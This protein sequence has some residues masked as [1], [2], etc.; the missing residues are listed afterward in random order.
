MRVP[1]FLVL[2]FSLY[3]SSVQPLT[4]ETRYLVGGPL[5][6]VEVPKFPTQHG[7]PDGHPGAT[8]QTEGE[9]Q[10]TTE[11]L[12][13]E[14]QLYPGSVEH[15]RAYMFKYMPIRS[16][17]DVQSQLKNW[18]APNIPGAQ[19]QHSEQYA[20]S[21]F[22]VPRHSAVR[23]TGLKLKPE[24]VIR[25]KVGTPEFELDLGEL[26]IG[27]Y[28]IRVI[29]A[30]APEQVKD[31]RL[32]AFLR[33]SVNDGLLGETSNYRL[34]IGY[35]EEFY[36]V[37]EFYFYAPAKRPYQSRLALDSGSQVDLLVHNVSLDDV[38]AG[39]ENRVLKKRTTIRS[40]VPDAAAKLEARRK[41]GH[42]IREPLSN[43]DRLTRDARIWNAF[44]P[45]NAQ[46][47]SRMGTGYGTVA[48]VVSGT[49]KMNAKE[50]E[51]EYGQWA[52]VSGNKK[53]D[54]FPANAILE[55]C[56]LFNDKLGLVYSM[57]DLRNNRPLPDPYPFK[58][59]GAGLYYPNPDNPA[60]GK[61]WSP[62]AERV[63]RVIRDYYGAGG[64]PQYMA[65]GEPDFAH[66]AVIQLVRY[67]YALPTLNF[68]DWIDCLV[69]T[70][71]AFGR[72]LRS[73][74]RG[75]AAFFMP[76]YP[77][78][79][80]PIM[81]QYDQ[82]FDF[83]KGN[84]Q[85]A[86]SIGRFVPWVKTSQDVIRLLDVYLVQTVAKR[87][88]RY[89]YHTDPVDIANLASVAGDNEFTKPWMDWLLSRTF[90]YPLPVSGIADTMI[91]GTCRDGGE[92]IGSSYYV[93]GENALR[94]ATSLQQYIEAGGDRSY[95]LSDAR[96][97]PKGLV[98]CYFRL[99]QIV[100]GWDFPRIGDVCGPDK[101]PGHTLRALDFAVYGWRWTKDPQFAF[102]LKHYVGS[103]GKTLG[104]AKS[105]LAN[106]TSKD[107][108]LIE[109]AAAN[110][111]RAPWLDRRSRVLPQ[112][113][114]FLETGLQH[115]DPRFRRAAYVRIGYGYGHH[116]N[117]G[118]DLQVS[119]HGIPMTIDGG[120]R[121]G[122]SSP[123]DRDTRVHNTV[124]I[125][126]EQNFLNSHATA[127]TDTPGA[128]YLAASALPTG[129]GKLLRRQISLV[130]VDEGIGSQPLPPSQQYP[131]SKLPEGVTP[132]NS[133]VFDVFR[134]AGGKA[135]TYNFHGPINDD[136]Q[137]NAADVKA[138]GGVPQ[139][140]EGSTPGFSPAGYLSAFNK[141][142]EQNR[143]GLA[144]DT[145]EVTWRQRR[146]KDEA[147]QGG[148]PF[149]GTEA[150]MMGNNFRYLTD[151]GI[152][153]ET[154]LNTS[155]RFMRLHLL[156]TKG[157]TAMQ[158]EAVCNKWNYHYTCAFLS[159]QSENDG[160]ESAFTAI[161]EPYIGQPFITSKRLL[162]IAGNEPDA[163]RGVAVEVKT[164]NGHTD[165]NFADGRPD[166][167]RTV[168]LDANK[169]TVAAE[170][171]FYSTDAAGLRIA[172]LTGG[173]KLF[174]PEAK[175][176]V[177][178]GERTATVS[179]VDYLEKTIWIDQQWPGRTSS[180]ILEIGLTN[181][182]HLTA[183][184]AIK[185]I[186]EENGT[187]IVFQRGS[188]YYRSEV[189]SIEG[190]T[191]T[192]VLDPMMMYAP[193]NRNGWVASNESQTR[194]WRAEF[195][196]KRQFKLSGPE[197]NKEAFGKEGAL[198]L[199]EYG[200]GD[201]VRQS[202]SASL[203]RI[204]PGD[205]E[206]RSDAGATISLR[207]SSI[208]TAVPGEGWAREEVVASDGWVS[209]RIPVGRAI[210]K[211]LR[212]RVK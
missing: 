17:F 167:T 101:L 178:T 14:M 146:Y 166:R 134:A 98:H 133:Y 24:P 76:H 113:A 171:A 107:W 201:K 75:T 202:T 53:P 160:L 112:W 153:D 176:E 20:S 31:F 71:G 142:P 186:P 55:D 84:E 41:A 91:T 19:E 47:H 23:D 161:I 6:G 172:T 103:A 2:F 128:S 1:L 193:G 34:R 87:I 120:Q 200:V 150:F 190:D 58:D 44:P 50:I 159:R 192:C 54:R 21:L 77:M 125:D 185:S 155:R 68:S 60:E 147:A 64:L 132:A 152:P 73:R 207:G 45:P 26:N 194:F 170:H 67:A 115:D 90:I 16:F 93:Q 191:V 158:A 118:L 183:Y 188:D 164:V 165:I 140:A 181:P 177:V 209:L 210:D 111:A 85:L 32:P 49:E 66:D 63:A 69:H 157:E 78:Y 204:E 4:A 15:Y 199:W 59:D 5:A 173:T 30:V 43:E 208:E 124:Q 203:V 88:M 130:D 83:I 51:E 162:P 28:T 86:K 184:T 211:A 198:R 117:D 105:I 116:H 99:N 108:D 62:V 81:Y 110:Q 169:L 163:L 179:K 22:W 106:M 196:D 139:V 8:G 102:I 39:T 141:L 126:Y 3:Y 149:A 97:Y 7:E 189:T 109:A 79:V 36:S 61:V 136:I 25:C 33:M 9:L 122:Y 27:L 197:V 205:Y 148:I 131:F 40:A 114:G 89:H 143:A 80:N 156:N 74:R 145:L 104:E 96:K 151:A 46:P 175:I 187:R 92:Y 94:V 154:Q 127:L 119:A 57:D 174:A 29:A 37:A 180:S 35:C 52:P 182:E 48:G 100:A 13:P 65:T 137:W 12:Y 206:F 95:D 121:P 10:F 144:P 168:M 123:G 135:H 11:D 56:F 82:L 129:A 138:L 72:D 195:L 70:R 212:I 42:T 18:V 38:L